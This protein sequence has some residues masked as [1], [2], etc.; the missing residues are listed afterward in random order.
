MTKNFYVSHPQDFTDAINE[1]KRLP[2]PMMLLSKQ[3]PPTKEH[4]DE[5]EKKRKQMA[6]F[7]RSVVPTYADCAGLTEEQA[8][9]ELQ[10]K[11]ARCGEII[12]N[13]SGEYDVVFLEKDK[14]RV[15]EQGKKYAVMSIAAM[16]NAE[17]AYLI[18]ESKNYILMQYGVVVKEIINPKTKEI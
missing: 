8:R 1:I 11:F 5:H 4:A 7:F 9:Y 16:N 2:Y 13:E 14:F 18:E 15:F 17:I 3:M 6:H 12:T 10:I